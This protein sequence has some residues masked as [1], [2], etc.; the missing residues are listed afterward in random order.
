METSGI[1]YSPMFSDF[2]S[3]YI[4][5][6]LSK[7]YTFKAPAS[8]VVLSPDLGFL[9]EANI[10]GIFDHIQKEKFPLRKSIDKLNNTI[11]E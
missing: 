5:E 3:S 9:E 6:S 1:F 11:K 2:V 8:W 7:I 4:K 10:Q